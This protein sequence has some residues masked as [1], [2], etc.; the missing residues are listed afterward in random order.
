MSNEII[1]PDH[2]NF[3]QHK[4][5]DVIQDWNLN[6]S[7]GNVIKYIARAGRKDG[8][9][10]LDDLRKARQYLDFEIAFLEKDSEMPPTV[11]GRYGKSIE[12]EIEETY[13]RRIDDGK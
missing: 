8:N 10:I 7:L 11:T 3:S 9:T 12:S 5:I 1:H 6:F 13:K 4:P 2:Y